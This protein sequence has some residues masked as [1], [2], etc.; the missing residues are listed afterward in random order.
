MFNPKYNITSKL[1][2]NI[3][4]ITTLVNE[5]NN[6]KYSKVVLLDYEKNAQALSTFASTSIEGNPLAL[7]EVKKILKNHPK[8]L[9]DTEREILNYNDALLEVNESIK[10]DLKLNEKFILNIHKLIMKDLLP[11]FN[12]GKWRK[13]PVFI[14]DPRSKKTVFLPPDHQKVEK[15]VKELL[16]FVEKNISELDPIIL[17]GIFHKQLV[18]IH[19]FIDGNGR[20]TRLATKLLLS[21]LG[22]DTFYLFSFENYYNQN[23]TKYFQHVGEFGD[24]YELEKNID[25]T[26]WLEYF[27]DGIIDELLRVKKEISHFNITPDNI[28]QKHHQ[29]ILDYINQ[30]GHINDKLY[31]KITDRAKATRALDFKKLI[32]LDLIIRLGKGPATIYKLKG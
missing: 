1:L 2:N 22:I 7:T 15:L 18:L 25:F 23:V 10:K 19:P 14:N 12:C 8:N 31:S 17:S 3:K 6:K 5:L 26:R 11:K 24:Y 16:L 29:L 13:G 27:S 4:Q 30:N 21:K 28:L 9:R 20:T 32:D